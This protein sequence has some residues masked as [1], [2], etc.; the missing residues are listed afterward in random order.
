M[1]S[2]KNYNYF[3]VG[4]HVAYP[5]TFFMEYLASKYPD[6]L[7]LVHYFPGRVF[8]EAFKDP[9]LPL[10]LRSLFK[11]GK[12]FFKPFMVAGKESGERVAFNASSKFPPR[13]S[14]PSGRTS[15]YFGL[16]PIQS[17]YNGSENLND[18][19]Q[20]NVTI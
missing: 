13:S 18:P 10:L 5:K 14:A 8:T 12:P 3:N 7:A 9:D 17:N 11:Y 6:K 1:R 4:S 20:S 2:P 19:I 15:T 16:N